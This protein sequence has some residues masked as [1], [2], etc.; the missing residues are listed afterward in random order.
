MAARWAAPVGPVIRRPMVFDHAGTL[1][2]ICP[3]MARA[4]ATPLVIPHLSKPVA[5]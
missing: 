1:P 3:E 2:R 5:R 4:A